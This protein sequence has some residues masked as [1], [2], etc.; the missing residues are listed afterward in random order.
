MFELGGSLQEIL[1]IFLVA[2]LVVG[3]KRLPEVGRMLARAMRELRRASDEFRSTIETNLY[4]DAPAPGPSST[5][6]APREPSSPTTPN[7][8]SSQLPTPEPEP[9]AAGGLSVE[10]FLAQRGS[11]LFHARECRW[12]ARIKPVDRVEFERFDDAEAQGL[13]RCPACELPG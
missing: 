9:G 11:R 3:P 2:L 5:E 10:P 12:A 8:T 4:L 7:V 1:V 13:R 6:P